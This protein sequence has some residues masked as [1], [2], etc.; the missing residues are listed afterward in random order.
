MVGSTPK[1][2]P[3]TPPPPPLPTAQGAHHFR[4]T[5]PPLP[6]QMQ[7]SRAA[8]ADAVQTYQRM[9]EETYR[10]EAALHTGSQDFQ[11]RQGLFAAPQLRSVELCTTKELLQ[12]LL[13]R[14]FSRRPS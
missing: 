2:K 4:H 14:L 1:D 3:E 5:S 10:K 7:Q 8:E 12:E 6:L 11:Q 9:V 13:R